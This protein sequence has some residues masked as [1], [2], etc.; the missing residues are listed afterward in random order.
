[1]KRS[2]FSL[3]TISCALGIVCFTNCKKEQEAPAFTES[4]TVAAPVSSV[5]LAT[6]PDRI[7]A[8]VKDLALENYSLSFAQTSPT[9]GITR[10]SYGTQGYVRLA[11][12]DNVKLSA[13]L[14]KYQ[15]YVPIWKRPTFVQPTCPEMVIDP[16]VLENLRQYLVKA[17]P[18]Q[19]S[20]LIEVGFV[21][22]G[23]FLASEKFVGQ[24]ANL[25]P[26]AFD[27]AAAGLDGA[28]FLMLTDVNGREFTRSFHGYANI[29]DIV[30][31][32]YK[33]NWADI[34]KPTLKGCF[35]PIVLKSIKEKLQQINPAT[36]SS[37][38]ITPLAENKSIAVMY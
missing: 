2:F 38:T 1:M 20:G 27:N 12:P 19:F 15:R 25:R 3:L 9:I 24:Y 32:P 14:R 31:K 29:N 6:T 37:L 26:D 7:D 13:E 4:A 16:R 10:T 5:S 17:D 23:G 8:I 30:L 28:R 35:D 18:S 22:G 21:T 11:N 33:K 34:F 36:Y